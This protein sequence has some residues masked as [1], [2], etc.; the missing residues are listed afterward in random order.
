M[1]IYHLSV[2]IVKRG[3]GRSA[4]AAAA[5]RAGEQLREER[6]GLTH[7]FTRK[8]GVEHSEILAPTEAPGWVHDRLVL[9]NSVERIEKRRDAQLAREVELGLPIEL[10]SFSQL[11]LLRQF[12]QRDFVARGMVADFSIH[13]DDPHNPHAHVLLTMRRV[14]KDGFGLKERAW[15]DRAALIAG[16][17]CLTIAEA[18]ANGRRRKLRFLCCWRI[19]SVRW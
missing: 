5:Y 12:V 7:D 1:A 17:W 13:R 2:K 9:W 4:V 10:D 6:T 8:Q 14:S 11:A 15:N 3:S 19:L 16:N 18:S